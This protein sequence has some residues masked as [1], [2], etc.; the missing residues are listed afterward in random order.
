MQCKIRYFGT[1]CKKIC[2]IVGGPQTEIGE[3]EENLDISRSKS[4]AIFGP[5]NFLTDAR[6]FFFFF[7]LRNTIFRSDHFCSG[8]RHLQNWKVQRNSTSDES[9]N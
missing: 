7:Y 3:E 6:I 9:R 1:N 8:K 4:D 2:S 5:I